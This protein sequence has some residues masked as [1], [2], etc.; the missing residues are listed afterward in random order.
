MSNC[1]GGGIWKAV[2]DRQVLSHQ[3]QV[4]VGTVSTYLPL[5]ERVERVLRPQST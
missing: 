5:N 2:Y 3:N 1:T 4:E